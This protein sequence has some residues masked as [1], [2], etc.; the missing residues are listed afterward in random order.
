MGRSGENPRRFDDG[1]L[2]PVVG[3]NGE[4]IVYSED[5]AASP[6]FGHLSGPGR[7]WRVDVA[8]AQ[9]TLIRDAD[10]LSPTVSPNG[11]R[12]GYWGLSVTKDAPDVPARLSGNG[13]RDIW[14]MRIDGSDVVRVTD[15][16]GIAWNPKWSHDGRYLY[17]ASDR[18]GTMNLWRQ[19]ISQTTGRVSGTLESIT[20]QTPYL[21]GFAVSDDGRHLVYASKT[22]TNNVQRLAIDP[23]TGLPEP[24]AV[25]QDVTRGTLPWKGT[26]ALSPDD[27]T[28]AMTSLERQMDIYLVKADGSGPPEPLTSDSDIDQE[29]AWID[30]NRIVF[31][32]DRGGATGVWMINSDRSGLRE[33]A[34][35]SQGP[36]MTP[37]PSRD[38]TRLFASGADGIYLFAVLDHSV[39]ES[40]DSI[41]NAG[42]SEWS[43]D[44]QRLASSSKRVVSVYSLGAK[45]SE[46]IVQPGEGVHWLSDDRRLIYSNGRSCTI[47]DTVTKQ[48]QVVYV[49]PDMLQNTPGCT[50]SHDDRWLYYL[51]GSQSTD[52]WMA[53]FK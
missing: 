29:P 42:V 53:T 5:R 15:G 33:I 14:T 44:G 28:L 13:H 49:V 38:G 3:P 47:V 30:K 22:E 19:E 24:G 1:R 18:G 6:Y 48:W 45:T 40:L 31:Q 41:P 20:M 27:R 37:R 11:Q 9:T 12:V 34:R 4:F 7:A 50:I 10:V 2:S 46:S 23:A 51:H 32:S 26:L 17:F 36:L 16:G 21:M 8:S 52:I 39:S 43:R 35:W 25:P